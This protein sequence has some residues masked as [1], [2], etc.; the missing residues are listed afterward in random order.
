[1]LYNKPTA[2]NPDD[3]RFLLGAFWHA[4]FRMFWTKLELVTTQMIR[5]CL[6]TTLKCFLG[7]AEDAEWK[8]GLSKPRHCPHRRRV[9]R[10][11]ICQSITWWFTCWE[12]QV[13]HPMDLPNFAHPHWCG[14]FMVFLIFL[15]GGK[16][17]NSTFNHSPW[18]LGEDEAIFDL[19]IF[20]NF[21]RLNESTNSFW[22]PMIL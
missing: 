9:T 7:N 13:V 16:F 3:F 14:F 4:K 1:M 20:F 22:V 15:G 18:T 11:L 17:R 5:T 10:S 19:R 8:T 12:I 21:K 2:R 6:I